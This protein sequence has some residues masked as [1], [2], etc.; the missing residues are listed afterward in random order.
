MAKAGGR[1]HVVLAHRVEA[2]TWD[3]HDS[4][5]L[6]ATRG[7]RL[8]SAASTTWINLELPCDPTGQLCSAGR[9]I[10]RTRT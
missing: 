7:E 9:Q 3:V 10:R 2:G 4:G 5:R 8:R 6:R 1:L